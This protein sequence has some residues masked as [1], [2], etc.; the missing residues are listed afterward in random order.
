[1]LRQL[2]D[3]SYYVRRELP[4]GAAPFHEDLAA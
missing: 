2:K 3:Q 4:E 1:L